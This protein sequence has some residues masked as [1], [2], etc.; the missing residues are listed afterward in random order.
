MAI[1]RSS[2]SDADEYVT[3]LL[4]ASRALVAISARSLAAMEDRVTVPQFRAL[5]VLSTRGEANLNRL[6]DDLGVAP[7]SAVRMIDRL[8]GAGLVT[9]RQNPDNRREVLIGLTP[10]GADIV[11]TATA[12]RRRELARVVAAMDAGQHAPLVDALTAFA[13]AAGEPVEPVGDALR[14]G[15]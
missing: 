4:A 12:A 11:D 13:R 8:V 6:A 1:R 10:D 5:V 2:P 9:R 15:W 14:L 7:S 3:A